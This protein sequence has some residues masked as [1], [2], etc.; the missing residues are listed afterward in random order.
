MTDERH[1]SDDRYDRDAPHEADA[2]ADDR[3]DRPDRDD[4]PGAELRTGFRALRAEIG[5]SGR[6]PDFA[7]MME[8]A[9]AEADAAPELVAARAPVASGARPRRA[10]MR[11]LPWIPVA[12]AAALAGLLLI[13]LPTSDAD[14]EFERLVAD[15]STSTAGGAWRSPTASLMAIPGVDLGAVP[16]VGGSLGGVD[17]PDSD[18]PEGRHP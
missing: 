6:V 18:A 5:A 1:D 14:T 16:S 17:R 2:R 15:Y 9:R 3:D 12:A 8:R 11:V 13:D 10:A 4:S 7:A